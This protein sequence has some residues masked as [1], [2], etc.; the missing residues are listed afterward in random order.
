MGVVV[1]DP[2]ASG[3]PIPG[4]LGSS[5][6]V[7]VVTVGQAPSLPLTCQCCAARTATA[8]EALCGRAR[9]HCSDRP[10]MHSCRLL[11]PFG[12]YLSTYQVVPACH[13]RSPRALRLAE[14]AELLLPVALPALAKQ[15]I[16]ARFRRGAGDGTDG[17][18]QSLF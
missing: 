11:L 4:Q 2:S 18:R 16:P 3:A 10:L 5:V 12:P 6:V 15:R 8:D 9:L 13:P 17:A 1:V 7:V 14:G